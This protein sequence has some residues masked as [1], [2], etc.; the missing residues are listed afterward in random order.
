MRGRDAF[1][2]KIKSAQPLSEFM[3]QIYSDG[4]DLSVAEHKGVLKQRAEEKIELV[5]SLVLKNALRQ[6]A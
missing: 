1:E 2:R 4:L 3:F 6:K 5:K